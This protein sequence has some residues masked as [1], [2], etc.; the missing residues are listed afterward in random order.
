MTVFSRASGIGSFRR[1]LAP[2]EEQMQQSESVPGWGRRAAEDAL[3]ETGPDMTRVPDGAHLASWADRT[4]LGPPV[5]QAERTSQGQ[6]RQPVPG[7]HHRRDRRI[8]RPHPDPPR[9]PLPVNR[10]PPWQ[11]Q[12]PGRRRQ[13][14][15]QGLAE[16]VQTPLGHASERPLASTAAQVMRLTIQAAP[17]RRG[18]WP[19]RRLPTGRRESG[20]YRV[21]ADGRCRWPVVPRV[22]RRRELQ[23]ARGHAL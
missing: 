4:P 16:A 15:A 13:H 6:E 9:R 23:C 18:R 19:C 10:P 7:R 22:R 21:R 12:S 11:A 1:L 14:P 3:A 8:R 20:R 2:Y 5:R 17:R